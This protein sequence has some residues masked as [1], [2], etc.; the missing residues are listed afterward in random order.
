MAWALGFFKAPLGGL[1]YSQA[2]SHCFQGQGEEALAQICRAGPSPRAVW[3]AR[4]ATC[5]LFIACLNYWVNIDPRLWCPRSYLLFS[6]A[7]LWCGGD[8]L[9]LGSANQEMGNTEAKHLPEGPCAK[10]SV[11][12]GLCGQA[13]RCV[14]EDAVVEQAN[15]AQKSYDN[16]GKCFKMS[17]PQSPH[18]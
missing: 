13:L 10:S 6:R 11:E 8:T 5:K 15:A 16:L 4:E 14:G 17:G 2:G 18:L 3:C 7:C 12:T 1:L 9:G